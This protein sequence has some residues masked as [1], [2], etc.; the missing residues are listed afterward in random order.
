MGSDFSNAGRVRD[1]GSVGG[2]VLNDAVEQ[3]D[4]ELATFDLVEERLV[5]AWGYLLRLPDRE[6]GWH[7]LKASWPNVRRHTAFGD[8][9]DMDA[10]AKPKLPGLR[11]AEVDRMEEALGWVEWVPA[12]H[13][14]LIG[15]VLSQLQRADRPEWPFVALELDRSVDPDAYRKRYSRALTRICERLNGAEIRR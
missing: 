4:R 3:L 10:D 1:Q 12:Q 9:G 13:R 11:T 15:V 6:K 2:R 14:A 8:Y 5:E 7:R